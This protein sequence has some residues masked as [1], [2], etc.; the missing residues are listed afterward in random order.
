M[1]LPKTDAKYYVV[2]KSFIIF[3][4]GQKELENNIEDIL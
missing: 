1:K 3:Y 2:L 4:F